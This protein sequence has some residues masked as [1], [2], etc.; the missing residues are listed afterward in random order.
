MI[1]VDLLLWVQGLILVGF[2]FFSAFNYLYAFAS[3]RRAAHRTTETSAEPVAVVVVSYNEGEVLRETLEACSRLTYGNRLVVL[4][5]DSDDPRIVGAQRD[6]ARAA[7]CRRIRDHGF[8]Q[9][10]P[11]ADGRTV[12]SPIEIWESESFVYFHRPRNVGFKGGSLR[13]VDEYLASRGIRLVYIL[14]ADWHPQ[15]DAIERTLEVLR[16][17]PAAAFVQTKRLSRVADMSLF[18]K[19]V[20]ISEEACYFVDFAG[21]QV[22][23]HPVLFSGCCALVNLDA[24]AAV[25]GF[26]HSDHLT[27]DLDLSNRLWL[28]GYRGIYLGSVVNRGEVPFTYQDLRRQQLRWAMGSARVLRETFR[29]VLRNPHLGVVHKLSVIR[30]NA[31]FASSL[32]T[33]SAVAVGLGTILWLALDRGSFGTEL[34]LARVTRFS[35]LLNAFMLACVFSTWIGSFLSVLVKDRRPV[36]LVHLPMAIWIAWSNIPTYIVGSLRGLRGARRSWFRTPKYVRSV[37]RP[38]ARSSWRL[39][40]LN[41]AIACGF[42]IL[43]VLESHL[44]GWHDFYA[45]LWIPAY[46][47]VAVAADA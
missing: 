21:R 2:C 33:G 19:Y 11:G 37:E 5:D 6:L 9:E 46:S 44:F 15:T 12:E 36:D 1:G 27:E 24:V 28:G 7:G 17:D 8:V 40:A 14:D 20:S 18:Q 16:A 22:L 42:A 39:R 34:Y 47:F 26:S 35:T 10:M 29:K 45:Y 3:L 38:R 23:G 41:G 13:K 31:Y 25:G 4:A 32:L 30:Q 43:Y